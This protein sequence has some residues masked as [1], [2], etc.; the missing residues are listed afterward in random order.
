MILTEQL[1]NANSV[2]TSFKMTND[3]NNTMPNLGAGLFPDRQTGSIKLDAISRHRPIDV[4]LAASNFNAMP[5]L[6]T[7]G[8]FKL[9]AREMA[10]FRESMQ[11]NE[12]D[13]I[14]L[15]KI[16]TLQNPAIDEIMQNIYDDAGTLIR[17]ASIVPEIMRMQLLAPEDGS[18]KISIIDNNVK[19]EYNYDTDGNYQTNNYI[20]LTSTDT[21][22]KPDS[23]KPFDN[24]RDVKRKLA[25]HGYTPAYAIMSQKTFDM[26]LAV[27]SIHNYILAQNLTATIDVNDELLRSVWRKNTGTQI[28]IYDK[29]YY[30]KESKTTKPFYPDGYVTFIPAGALG[31]TWRGRTPEERT[32]RGDSKVDV[33]V[34]E[35]GVAIAVKRDYGPPVTI[36]T[37]ASMIV[38]PTYDRMDETFVLK[39]VE[40]E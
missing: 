26:L 3:I 8:T 30:D 37:V 39:V 27:K 20:A 9:E 35:D 40:G 25:A 17:G 33:S 38:L 19:Y 23:A 28:I 13:L 6:R 21:W 4:Q 1:F 24:F 2:V 11:V 18:P 31:Y 22:D 36:T 7:R 29:M 14:Q 12:D 16:E 15:D 34:M 5:T 32:L 10:F